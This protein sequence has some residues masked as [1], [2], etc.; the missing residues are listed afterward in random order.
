[1]AFLKKVFGNWWVTSLL[2]AVVVA[3]LLCLVLPIV[4]GPLR[5]LSWRLGLLAL[6]ALVW[7]GATLSRQLRRRAAAKRLEAELLQASDPEGQALA[8]R[9][10]EALQTLKSASGSKRDYLYDRPW[11]VVIGP[12]GAG[13]STAVQASGLRFPYSNALK[14]V[15][16]TRN[17]DF[18]FADEAVL[19]D[20][21]GR[22]T[23]QDSSTER[24]REGWTS[25]LRQL[26][27]NRPLQPINGVVVAFGLDTLMAGDVAALDAHANTV[28]RRLAELHQ[29]LEI[30]PPV[31]VL[32]TKADLLAGFQEYFDDLDVEGRRA[33]LGHTFPLDAVPDARTLAEAF[34]EVADSINARL[35]SRLN[36]ELDARRLSLALGFPSQFLSLRARVA[37]FLEGA[38]PQ[39]TADAGGHLRG[40]YLT[41]GVQQGTPIDRLLGVAAGGAPAAT[42]P[43]GAGRAYFI[44]R[45]LQE[46]ILG[47][48]GLVR[49]TPESLRRR[50]TMLTAA[51]AGI[52]AVTLLVLMAWTVSFIANRNYQG[53]LLVAANRVSQE[54]K[55]AGLD[56]AEV[57]ASD[58]DL[59]AALPALDALRGLPQGYAARRA[60]GAPIYMRFGLFQSHLSRSAEQAYLEGLNRV[61][62]PR[63]LLR[64]EDYIRQHPTDPMAVYEP[65]KGY[66]ML[67]G[68]HAL[69]AKGI[70]SWVISDWS[71][72][73]LPGADRE[74]IRKRLTQ[75]LDGM[76]ADKGFGRVWANRV[77]PLDATLV[78]SSRAQVATLSMADRAYALLRQKA[79]ISGG[80]D[81]SAGQVLAVGQLQAFANPA[82]AR[83]LSVPY[84]YTKSGYE[85]A[86]RV[87]LNTV[88]KDLQNDLW[89]LGDDANKEGVRAQMQGL[90]SG[91]ANRYASDY[92][93][94]WQGVLRELQPADYFSDP[95]A[96][97]AVLA[98]PSPLKV[99]LLAVRRETTFQPD[100]ADKAAQDL[101]KRLPGAALLGPV[102]L[103]GDA[104]Q[105]IQQ[106]FQSVHN[107]VGDGRAPGPL[108]DYLAKLKAALDAKAFLDRASG[109][110]SADMAR[111]TADQAMAALQG[112]AQQ[113][114]GDLQ[115]FV[116]RS[117]EQGD[118]ARV[119]GAADAVVRDYEAALKGQC[120]AVTEN[121]YPFVRAASSDA[122]VGDLL[123]LFG[124]GAPLDT[125]RGQL[126]GYIDQLQVKWRWRTDNPIAAAF[127]PTSAEEF[128][129][130]SVIRDLL[131]TGVPMQVEAVAFGAGATAAELSIGGASKRFDKGQGGVQPFQW[132]R[133][134]SPEARLTIT[135]AQGPRTFSYSGP[136]AVF[137]LFDQ[138]RLENAGETAFKATFGDGAAFATL[139]VTLD[140]EMNP[141]SR[142][143][144]WS[145]RCPPKL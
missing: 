48:A 115:A 30:T 28:R 51:L 27:R 98:G 49:A 45:L 136:W 12:P 104:G 50:R 34:D 14:G 7:G 110:A 109:G 82:A 41:S 74:D 137:R 113:A 92:V 142:G 107:F 89:V 15:G 77:A 139:R 91:V 143:G 135:T 5:P 99:L 121:R 33:V 108:D 119:K 111:A 26:R 6:V 39:G 67:G 118:A 22:Y 127:D 66:L 85:R 9:M 47:E 16:G 84:F 58:P 31:Y 87:G 2:I 117:T 140:S 64:I 52:A 101:A 105:Q 112:A 133:Q 88:Q 129:K 130:A 124:S 11:Y 81:W 102:S 57:R 103:G 72:D 123:R 8:G 93:A 24:D 120:V 131:D 80:P 125:F 54:T 35:S 128:Q 1:M 63:I 44:N 38:F 100:R 19:V 79:S 138:A 132:S 36:A 59:E 94:A 10:S 3:L 32:F 86:Y 13:K 60:G 43:G 126:S 70:R 46:V 134:G 114:P 61:L 40:F 122:R 97:S 106:Q 21:A 37:R 76:L 96:A 56:L 55:D 116:G 42:P 90:R 20:T 25:L 18:W 69:E 53:A 4:V 83:A 95:G 23:S 17:L 29:A 145:F 141:F 75:H 62:L 144:P 68:H 71:S 73:S 78:D 65:L